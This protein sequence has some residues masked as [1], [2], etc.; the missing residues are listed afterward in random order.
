MYQDEGALARR[1]SLGLELEGR[2]GRDGVVVVRVVP[3]GTAALAGLA[4]GDRVVRVDGEPTPDAARV[5]AIA[6][7]RERGGRVRFEVVRGAEALTLEGALSEAPREEVAGADVV[8]GHVEITAGDR[9]HRLRT[10]RTIPRGAAP[11]ATVLHLPGLGHGSVELS[12]DP[13]D[14]ARRLLEGL[15]ALGLSTLRVER[16]GTGDS[17]GPPARELGFFEELAGHRAA[18][19]ALRAEGARVLLLGHSV[20]GM[21]AP[22]LADEASDV[23]GVIVT[24]SSSLRWYECILQTTQRQR[25]L[26]GATGG[27]LEAEMRERAELY[28]GVLREGLLPEEVF[29]RAPRLRAHEGPSCRGATIFGRH[30]RFFQELERLDLPRLWSTVIAPVLVA[31]GEHDWVCTPDEG[32][33]IADAARAGTFALLPGLGHDLRRYASLAESFARR[34]GAWDGS[35][36]D[37]I[38]AWLRR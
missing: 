2:S 13:D 9:R 11:R 3:G 1:C 7:A 36:V 6:S 30:A 26:G 12:S 25:A 8:L 17:E 16:S 21:M 20:G 14:D 34:G 28:A 19:G 37:A 15:T 31:H 10:I 18:Q 5:V 35:A 4:A 27:A 38:G 22:L 23:A 29:A 24:G 32:R 33:A